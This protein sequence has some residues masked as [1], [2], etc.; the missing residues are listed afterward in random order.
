M[1]SGNIEK[2]KQKFNKEIIWRSCPEQDTVSET[3]NVHVVSKWAN[4]NGIGD[5]FRYI[6]FL[7]YFELQKDISESN[8]LKEMII[9]TGMYEVKPEYILGD[10]KYIKQVEY[11][12]ETAKKRGINNVPAIMV[13]GKIFNHNELK[14][15]TVP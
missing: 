15:L 5:V 12:I 1:L 13:E 10:E 8:V 4:E 14:K 9:K 2:I 7:T 3:K 6:A 11:D